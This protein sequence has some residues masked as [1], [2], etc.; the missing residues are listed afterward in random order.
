[1]RLKKNDAIEILNESLATGGDYSEIYYQDNISHSYARRYKKVFRVSSSRTC[2][3][4]LRILKGDQVVYGYTSDLSKSSLLNLSKNLAL[5]FS[6]DRIKTVTDLVKQVNKK[7]CKIKKSH[8]QMTT[9]EK[10]SYLERG[11][12]AAFE[13]DS[14]IQDVVVSLAEEDE[15]VEIY[16]SD[17]IVT[18]DNRCRTRL[19]L[20]AIATDGNS[21]QQSFEGPGKSVG[22]E[23]LDE[24]DFEELGKKNARN[25]VALLTAEDGP[26]GDM[27]VVLGNYFGGVLFHEACGHPLEGS[28]ISHG[29]SPFNGKLGKQIANPVV[30]AIDDGTIKN[31]WGSEDVDDEG[32]KPT[33]NQLI[34]D[35]VLTNYMVDRYTSRRIEGSKATGS[36]RRESYRYVPTTRMTNT[37]IDNGKNTPNEVISSVKEGIYCKGFTGGQVDPSTDKFVFTS[38]LAYTIKDGK[39]DKLIKPVSLIGYGY[40][41]LQRI[42]M[43]ANDLSIAPGMCG[44][45]S[46]SCA[47]SVGQPTLRISKITVGGTKGE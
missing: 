6:G 37:Y 9:Q 8:D 22:L 29:S 24:I 26:S 27:P 43:V 28:T 39:I 46:G 12:K 42:D 15:L 19:A 44:A 25:A 33:K 3:I 4:G 14:K 7:I 5:G 21:F 10:L 23:L 41:I 34:K 16:N 2:G 1:M 30:N 47:V 31:G 17:G 11:E 35:G 13:I 18:K 40:E 32:I 38:D 36:C 45:S 20:N